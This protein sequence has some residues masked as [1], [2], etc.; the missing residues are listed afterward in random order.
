MKFEVDVS[1]YDIFN[2][3]DYTICISNNEGTGIIKGFKFNEGL[4]NSLISNWK[5]NKYRYF[6]DTLETKRGIFKVRIYCIILHYLFN[7]IAPKPDFVSLTLCR[8]FKGRENQ[9]KQSVKYLLDD[10]LNIKSGKPQ[11]QKL[12]STSLAHIYAGMMRGDKKN[13]FG[14]Y[15]NISLGDIERYL[16]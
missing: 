7:S 12:P 5:S 14:C 3:K 13:L 6:Y 2:E 15:V 9:I 8:D 1:G 4:I 10:K 16:L 11:F